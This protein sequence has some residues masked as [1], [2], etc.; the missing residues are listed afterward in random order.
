MYTDNKRFEW[1]EAKAR[2][3]FEKHRISFEEAPTAFDDPHG[4]LAD[5]A[6]HSQR[7]RRFWLIGESAAMR[8]QV[9]V[10]TLRREAIRIISARPS[11]WKERIQYEQNRR[12]PV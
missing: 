4:L 5:D 11:G 6:A 10:F 12:I 9:V 7:E 1:D 3:N 2:R 8:L